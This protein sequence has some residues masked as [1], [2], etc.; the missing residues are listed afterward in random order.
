MNVTYND[1][2]DLHDV[3]GFMADTLYGA[4]KETEAMAKG[5]RCRQ[6]LFSLSLNPLEKSFV[7]TQGFE[8]AINEIEQALK[9]VGQPRAIVFH[10]KAGRRHAHVAF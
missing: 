4:F 5:T 9:L 10:E 7:S 3:R 6:Y 2:V 1:R 8:A